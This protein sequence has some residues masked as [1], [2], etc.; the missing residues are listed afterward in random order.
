[1]KTFWLFADFADSDDFAD[2]AEF[3][4][5]PLS[6]K[7]DIL[8]ATAFLFQSLSLYF[9]AKVFSSE[10]MLFHSTI[11]ILNDFPFLMYRRRNVSGGITGM[12]LR[13]VLRL[14]W[15]GNLYMHRF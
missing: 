4:G 15:D 3:A 14:G 13:L 7:F 1:M 9:S 2:C 12:G 11:A 10:K 5:T 6:I 8:K